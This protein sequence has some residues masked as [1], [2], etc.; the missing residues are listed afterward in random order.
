MT[1]IADQLMVKLAKDLR[2]GAAG[3]TVTHG[4]EWKWRSAG[5]QE[6]A[7]AELQHQRSR[8]L[9]HGLYQINKG[10]GLYPKRSAPA[11]RVDPDATS[12]LWVPKGR[13]AGKLDALQPT[14]QLTNHESLLCLSSRGDFQSLGF[15]GGY[16]DIGGAF[17]AIRFP[18]HQVFTGRQIQ[19]RHRVVTCRDFF[20]IIFSVSFTENFPGNIF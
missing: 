7:L 1:F 8:V 12:G 9:Y 4:E 13:R 6:K 18:S 15:A 3:E 5:V 17:L 2:I 11:S 14:N 10:P 20:P 16:F 19:V